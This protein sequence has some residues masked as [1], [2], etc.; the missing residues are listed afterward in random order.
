MDNHNTTG[1]TI[2]L[3]DDY[4]INDYPKLLKSLAM[5]PDDWDVLRFDLWQHPF[6]HYPHFPMEGIGYGF[7]SLAPPEGRWYCGGTHLT[8][9]RGDKVDKLRKHWDHYPR[10]PIDCLLAR[11]NITSYGLMTG[12]GWI[13]NARRSDIPKLRYLQKMSLGWEDHTEL[14]HLMR[15]KRTV[16][17]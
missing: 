9:W 13:D 3:E 6:R 14:R 4:V 7:R 15:N 11:D 10:K 16:N 17:F 12:V 5:V 8:V 2:V 1:I